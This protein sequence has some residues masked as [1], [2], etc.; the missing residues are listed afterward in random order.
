MLDGKITAL[1]ANKAYYENRYNR[2]L[3]GLPHAG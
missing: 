3:E 1:A 2:F